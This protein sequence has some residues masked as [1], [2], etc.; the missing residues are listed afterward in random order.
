MLNMK[1]LLRTIFL[2]VVFFCVVADTIVQAKEPLTVVV[3]ANLSG[4][5]N[6]LKDVFIATHKDAVVEVIT[7]ASGKL[8]MQ[9]LNGAPFDVFLSADM[10][11]P[12]KL[13]DAGFADK[14]P[15]K[16]AVGTLIMFTVKDIDLKKGVTIVASPEVEKISIADPALAPYGKAAIEALE[17]SNVIE[18]ARS[19]FVTANSISEVVSQTINGADVGFTALALMHSESMKQYNIEGKYWVEINPALYNPI[20]QGMVIL[21]HGKDKPEAKAFYDFV[22]S[23]KAHT[24]FVKYGYK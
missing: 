23:K 3:A 2:M 24:I 8:A 22:L 21:K 17:N 5:I 16:Y 11:N 7:G 19:K 20:Q 1:I 18:I 14:A 12:Q 9:V 6:E 10:D 4:I 15:A 13:R